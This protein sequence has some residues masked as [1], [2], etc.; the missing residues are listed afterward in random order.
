MN[1]QYAQLTARLQCGKGRNWGSAM[2]SV[3][4]DKL[5]VIETNARAQKM[6]SSLLNSHTDYAKID[7]LECLMAPLY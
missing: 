1:D 3:C 4:L 6:R 2:H 5:A 7:R